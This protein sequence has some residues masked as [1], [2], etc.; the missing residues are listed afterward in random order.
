VRGDNRAR[1]SRRATMRIGITLFAAGFADRAIAQDSQ[2]TKLDQKTVMYQPVPKEGHACNKCQHFEAPNT[3]K[4][5][6][7][8]ISPAGWCQLWAEK[9]Q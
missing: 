4:L 6:A 2:P 3:C 5:V 8:T 1:V 7:G 9:T